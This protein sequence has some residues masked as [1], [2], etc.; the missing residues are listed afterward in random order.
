[1]AAALAALLAGCDDSDGSAGASAT[2]QAVNSLMTR[3]A[4]RS[5]SGTTGAPKSGH[6]T[7]DNATLYWEAPTSNTN[8]TAL[9][10]LT[11]YRIY[12]GESEDKM[13]E[14]VQIA[15]VGIQT[16]VIENLQAGTWYFAVRALSRE[17]TE[18]SLSDIVSK[19]IG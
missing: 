18:S 8:G 5:G 19:T 13:T 2:P 1:M 11:G 9:T 10:D 4:A 16:Y 7:S 14:T 6:L 12:Y 17:G 15:D 3:A